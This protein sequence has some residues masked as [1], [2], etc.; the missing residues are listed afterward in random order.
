MIPAAIHLALPPIALLLHWQG[1]SSAPL[2]FTCHHHHHQGAH[3]CYHPWHTCCCPC[4]RRAALSVCWEYQPTLV[5]VSYSQLEALRVSCSQRTLRVTYSQHHQ[6]RLWYSQR[7]ST[8][9]RWFSGHAHTWAAWTALREY[10]TL[11]GQRW[12]YDALSMQWEDQT[13]STARWEYDACSMRARLCTDS[14]S[15]LVRSTAAE[16]TRFWARF[17][18]NDLQSCAIREILAKSYRIAPQNHAEL[19]PKLLLRIPLYVIF[20]Y[21]FLYVVWLW[22]FIAS[23]AYLL[24]P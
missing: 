21:W 2:W 17:K 18:Q 5:E 23:S 15:T 13:S 10:H 19:V 4:P 22:V 11:S 20:L 9:K 7:E 3:C 8:L 12:E 16:M 6:L 14:Q 24:G 1:L